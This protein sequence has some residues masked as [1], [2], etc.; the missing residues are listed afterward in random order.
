ML[1]V[2]GMPV[3]PEKGNT[4]WLELGLGLGLGLGFQKAVAPGDGTKSDES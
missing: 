2:L 3:C 4:L 1:F